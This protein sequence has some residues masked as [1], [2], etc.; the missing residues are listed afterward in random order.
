[1]NRALVSLRFLV[2]VT[3]PCARCWAP[4]TWNQSCSHQQMSWLTAGNGQHMPMS[5]TCQEVCRY[6]YTYIKC[7]SRSQSITNP[8]IIVLN[9][10]VKVEISSCICNAATTLYCEVAFTLKKIKRWVYRRFKIYFYIDIGIRAPIDYF[11]ANIVIRRRSP[12]F[13]LSMC[14]V[15]SS[16]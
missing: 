6:S 1:M 15:S 8:Q 4:P 16:C 12:Q 3:V 13:S 14:D 5:G 9:K 10:T 11:C 2:T 7:K